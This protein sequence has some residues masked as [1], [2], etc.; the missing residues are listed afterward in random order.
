MQI[1]A[2][3]I[4]EFCERG[5]EC[6]QQNRTEKS[7]RMLNSREVTDIYLSRILKS[8]DW[9]VGFLFVLF[10]WIDQRDNVVK[11]NA[12]YH[13]HLSLACNKNGFICHISMEFPL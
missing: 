8:S 13:L 10:Y 11:L 12:I 7:V 5:N 6:I 2:N 3:Y 9:V 1:K 4:E